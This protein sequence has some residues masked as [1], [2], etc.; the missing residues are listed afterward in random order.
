MTKEV[1]FEPVDGPI[2]GRIDET[3]QAKYTKSSYLKPMI[4]TRA[5]GA[6]AKIMPR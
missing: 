1:I 5:R 3:Y 6:T 2:N 4:S